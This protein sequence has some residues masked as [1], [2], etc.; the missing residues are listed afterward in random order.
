VAEAAD[1]LK[2]R[3]VKPWQAGPGYVWVTKTKNAMKAAPGTP[4]PDEALRVAL[5]EF[6]EGTTVDEVR[7]ALGIRRIQV[8]E[9]IE[10]ERP[11]RYTNR[12]AR[13][14]AAKRVL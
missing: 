11:V 13:R 5:A 1:R 9:V 6:P 7:Q 8:A 3:S 10:D 14:A 12:A 4:V 2:A